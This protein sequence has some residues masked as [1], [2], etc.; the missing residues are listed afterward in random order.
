M[1]FAD[2]FSLAIS[3]RYLLAILFFSIGWATRLSLLPQTAGFGYLAFYPMVTLAAL[4]L[5]TGPGFVTLVLSAVAADYALD[6]PVRSFL[7]SPAALRPPAMFFI[8]GLIVCF[9]AHKMRRSAEEL[10]VSKESMEI[11]FDGA[12]DAALIVDSHGRITKLNRQVGVLLGF[13]DAELHG[14]PIECL[15]PERFRTSHVN[16]RA[17]FGSIHTARP[18]GQGLVVKALRKDGAEIDVDVSLSPIRTVHGRFVVCA[19]RDI[20]ERKRTEAK[21]QEL[22]FIDQLTGLP[23]RTLFMDRLRQAMTVSAR[24]QQYCALLFLDLDNFK[25][26]NDTLGHDTGDRLLQQAGIR[27]KE[28]VRAG[29]TVARLGGDEFVVILPHLSTSASEAAVD[30]EAIAKK[31][32]HALGQLYEFGGS[33]H[34]STCS[35]GATL[36]RGTQVQ[37]DGLLKQADMTMYKS[38]ASGGNAVRFFDSA[39]ETAVLER[40]ALEA[41]LRQALR[42]GQFFLHYQA[43]VTEERR[44]SGA[45]A[46]LRWTHPQ[47]GVVPPDEFI[48]LAEQTRI[49]LPLGQWVLES[50]CRQLAIWERQPALAHLTLAVNVSALQ[51]R[52]AEFVEDVFGAIE[53]AGANPERLKLELT[54]SLLVDDVGILIDKMVA[55]KARGVRFSLD[56]F[57][58]G[59]SSLSYLKRLPLDQLKIDRSFIQ[60]VLTDPNDAAIARTIVALSQTLGLKVIAEGVENEDQLKFLSINGCH[61]FQGFLFSR[62]VAEDEFELLVSRTSA[63]LAGQPYRDTMRE[64]C[65]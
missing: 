47:R 37:I 20:T 2:A 5:G 46:L 63:G 33:V 52:Q 28:S 26:L 12:P 29:D 21:I 48:P 45:E 38:K 1:L 17:D 13:D 32:L 23:N 58:T 42:E 11:T 15:I 51:F 22:A 43:Q 31:I 10:R 8:S 16:L 14:K 54:E 57:G 61:A 41:D 59:Y 50:A 27:L 36:F 64:K 25:G 65:Q 39:M 7:L 35:I 18:M 19:M 30:T 60:D 4:L 49:I 56:D 62:P 6:A 55:L 44:I 9:F 34:Q 3:T 40:A 24:S 53:R